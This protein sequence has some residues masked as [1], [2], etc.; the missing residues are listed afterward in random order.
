MAQ[1]EMPGVVE[2]DLGHRVLSGDV[3]KKI[4]TTAVKLQHARRKL[5]LRRGIIV[6]ELDLSNEEVPYIVVFSGFCFAAPV[7]ASRSTFLGS[8]TFQYTYFRDLVYFDS[9]RIVGNFQLARD[10]FTSTKP[11][12]VEFSGMSVDGTFFLTGVD[13]RGQVDLSDILVRRNF[14]IVETD[15][16]STIGNMFLESA[17]IDGTVRIYEVDF[18]RETSFGG[19][20]VGGE[21]RMR[22][23]HFGFEVPGTF[24]GG[25]NVAGKTSFELVKFDGP[26]YFSQSRFTRLEFSDV[27]WPSLMGP[28]VNLDGMIY[29]DIQIDS[30]TKDPLDFL[31]KAVYSGSAYAQLESL[32][33]QDGNL[34]R[35]ND[36]YIKG[37]VHERSI[38][39]RTLLSTIWSGFLQGFI[40]YGRHPL[41]AWGWGA[42]IVVVGTFLFPREKMVPVKDGQSVQHESGYERPWPWVITRTPPSPLARL[43]HIFVGIFG[44]HYG[45]FWYSLDLFAPVIDLGVAKAWT[46]HPLAHPWLM[47]WMHIQRLLGWVVVPLGLAAVTG[48]IK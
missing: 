42:F 48:F 13:A 43:R 15:A 4:L 33:K 29:Q 10:H 30:P 12:A 47:A 6:S 21:F 11:F 1:F 22:G 32:A 23:V 3:I 40:G 28:A 26:V 31:W 8:L 35:A 5:T 7:I 17:R 36:I 34:E 14:E 20:I 9:A 16:K 2:L 45:S 19:T 38:K 46:P 41:W 44:L 18:L 25:M 24:L 39:G 27:K 37:K